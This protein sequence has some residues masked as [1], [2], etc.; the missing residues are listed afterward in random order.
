MRHGFGDGWEYLFEVSA[1]SHRAGAFDGFIETWHDVFPPAPGRQGPRAP[2]DRP[3]A[4]L[5]QRRENLLRYRPGVFPRSGMSASGLAMPCRIGPF[6]TTALRSGA[7][8]TLP[9]GDEASLAGSGGHSASLWA[10]TSGALPGSAGT[11]SWLYSASLGALAGEAPRGLP[12]LGNRFVAFGHLGAT[13]RPLGHLSLTAQIN[14]HSSPY[15]A[16]DVAPLADPGVMIGLGG[17]V[18]LSKHATLEIAV[19]RR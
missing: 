11:R 14:A 6:R 4:V 7:V 1:F 2:R 17:A 5:R 13:W 12:D 3:R 19:N 18:R 15:G 16:S 9:T 10:E 8:S